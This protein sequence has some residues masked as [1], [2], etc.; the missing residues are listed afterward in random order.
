MGDRPRRPT[1]KVM[2]NRQIFLA[3][4]EDLRQLV[5]DEGMILEE[6]D[7]AAQHLQTAY[8][9]A[10]QAAVNIKAAL[11]QIPGIHE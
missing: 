11:R 7:P 9:N 10:L 6:T 1:G 2:S 3:I 4:V 5:S 8:R